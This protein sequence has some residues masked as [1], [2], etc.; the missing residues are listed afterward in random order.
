[1]DKWIPLKVLK[2]PCF[3]FF[4]AKIAFSP[5]LFIVRYVSDPGNES[6]C[7]TENSE[8]MGILFLLICFIAFMVLCLEL[9]IL[10]H[11]II[12]KVNRMSDTVLSINVFY[13]CV[14]LVFPI[15]K[16]V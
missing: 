12:L 11:L 13:I 2:Y 15:K 3:C 8:I 14:P 6:Q 7:R 9:K 5:P 1:M 10:I 4:Y 16:M